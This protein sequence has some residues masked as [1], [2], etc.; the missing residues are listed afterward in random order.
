MSKI[1]W[2]VFAIVAIPGMV[3]FLITHNYIFYQEKPLETISDIVFAI[4]N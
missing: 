3:L 1:N 4:L 2:K